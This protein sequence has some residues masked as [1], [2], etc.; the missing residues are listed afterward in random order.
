MDADRDLSRGSHRVGIRLICYE[1]RAVVARVLFG[2]TISL[3]P[4]RATRQT[5]SSQ[6]DKQ[7]L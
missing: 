7:F 2:C 4:T 5:Q 1:N 6:I 3:R